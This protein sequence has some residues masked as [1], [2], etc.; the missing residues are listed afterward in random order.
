M[1]IIFDLGSVLVEWNPKKFIAEFDITAKQKIL[2][3]EELYYHADWLALDK[4]TKSEKEV[5]AAVAKRTLMSEQLI[6]ELFIETRKT[7]TEIKRTSTLLPKLKSNGHNLYCLSNMSRETFD[8]LKCFEFFKYFDDIIISAHIQMM[9]PDI[10]IFNFMIKKFNI[11]AQD[12]VF[13]DDRLENIQA[14]QSVGIKGILFDQSDDAYS[15]I[16]AFT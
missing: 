10:E 11:S 7:H 1:N 13:I 5:I 14:A 9:K 6:G 8:Y 4:G 2:I 16:A 3:A 12:S 15:K